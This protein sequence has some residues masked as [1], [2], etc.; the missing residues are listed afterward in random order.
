M[1]SVVPTT[2]P[3]SAIVIV[4]WARILLFK[5]RAFL[6]LGYDECEQPLAFGDETFEREMWNA[7]LAIAIEIIVDVCS[8]LVQSRQGL[9]FLDLFEGSKSKALLMT[10]C[11][12]QAFSTSILLFTVQMRPIFCDDADVC[13]CEYR[14]ITKPG[15]TLYSAC[16]PGRL[17]ACGLDVACGH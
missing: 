14:A 9:P 4:A 8:V 5:H 7:A 15:S 3:V 1:T 6:D 13:G 2:T 11:C 12:M 16:W 10:L 17:E